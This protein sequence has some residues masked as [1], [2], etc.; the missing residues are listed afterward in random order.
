MQVGLRACTLNP[1]RFLLIPVQSVAQH[2]HGEGFGAVL[3][4]SS[5]HVAEGAPT[6]LFANNIVLGVEFL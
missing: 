4:G 5:Q 3:A 1:S 6:Q 2:L